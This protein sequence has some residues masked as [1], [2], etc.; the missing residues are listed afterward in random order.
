MARCGFCV[1]VPDRASL[2]RLTSM[3]DA[4]NLK[5]VTV[6]DP[7]DED[8]NWPTP[9]CVLGINQTPALDANGNQIPG[10]VFVGIGPAVPNPVKNRIQGDG[11]N[12]FRC[13]KYLWFNGTYTEAQL[14][15]RVRQWAGEDGCS[16]VW[17]VNTD[18]D[19][20]TATNTA[21]LAKFVPV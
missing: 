17:E 9:R 11:G 21:L 15:P 10:E 2:A 4:I 3:A 20:T 13:S 16:H 6:Q 1:T 19:L 12:Y 14:A 8:G 5:V 18:T 7:P